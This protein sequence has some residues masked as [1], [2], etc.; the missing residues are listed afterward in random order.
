MKKKTNKR[1]VDFRQKAINTY[2]VSVGCEICGYNKHPAS[3][4]FDHVGVSEK[5]ESVKNGYSKR[6]S[7]GGMYMLYHRD[8][9]Y[10]IIINEIKK[11][12]V[13]CH[14]C[15][16]EQTHSKKAKFLLKDISNIEKLERELASIGE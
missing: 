16:M 2:K 7:A 8:Y 4:C 13:L 6:S 15:H 3:L 12:R 14:N 11:C 5:H 10:S 9:H 1:I